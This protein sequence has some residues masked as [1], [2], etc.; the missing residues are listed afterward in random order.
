M[1]EVWHLFGCGKRQTNREPTLFLRPANPNRRIHPLYSKGQVAEGC[2]HCEEM[3]L[4]AGRGL[5]IH[6][7]V[8]EAT[9][10]RQ[11]VASAPRSTRTHQPGLIQPKGRW[12]QSRRCRLH[13]APDGSP[14]LQRVCS[15]PKAGKVA[16][17]CRRAMLRELGGGR[18]RT[19]GE[20]CASQLDHRNGP[21]KWNTEIWAMFLLLVCL[22]SHPTRG[23]VARQVQAGGAKAAGWGWV[24]KEEEHRKKSWFG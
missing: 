10:E 1:V 23:G 4:R 15:H 2:S 3:P 14:V 22:V 9:P 5:S 16:L 11:C 12:I 18:G 19:T 6:V 13:E 8:L 7:R 17:R 20:L 21:Q 24:L